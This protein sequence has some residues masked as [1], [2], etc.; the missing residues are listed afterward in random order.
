MKVSP[1][2]KNRRLHDITLFGN[3]HFITM[4]L[5]TVTPQSS[6]LSLQNTPYNSPAQRGPAFTQ[7]AYWN[8]SITLRSILNA[9][10][11]DEW[12]KELSALCEEHALRLSAE[13]Y[14][15]DTYIRSVSL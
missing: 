13:I 7:E 5:F 8:Q 2:L 12:L 11:L 10:L 3:T 9:V 4:S 6:P 15:D 1:E 14:E